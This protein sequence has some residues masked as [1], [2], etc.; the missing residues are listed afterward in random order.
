MALGIAQIVSWGT[1][2]YTIAVLGDA[3]RAE[4][5]VSATLLFGA[6]SAG[7]FVSGAASP[8]RWST[9]SMPDMRAARSPADSCAGAVALA[10]LALRA[11]PGD[12]AGGLDRRGR[13]DGD[14]RFTI[15][16]SRCCTSISGAGYRR[17]ITALHAVRRI[18]RALFS[19]RLS[20]WL[21]NG[22]G[23]RATFG[24]LCGA[25]ISPS[26]CLCIWPPSHA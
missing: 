11:G 14:A 16:R 26:A 7:L 17:A 4:L 2:F 21:L 13:C 23:W 18:R 3:M 20:L 25:C 19:G 22:F 6:F 8:R 9:G 15:R 24:I 10:L 12:A 5:G 1:L